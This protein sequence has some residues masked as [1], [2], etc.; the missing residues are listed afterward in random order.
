MG[1]VIADLNA[2]GKADI[3]ASTVSGV[4]VLLGNGDGTFRNV[5]NYA[6]GS[7]H[8]S[9]VA[10]DFTRDGKIDLLTA[11]PGQLVTGGRDNGSL[12]LRPGTGDGSFGE[13]IV[14]EGGG[15]PYHIAVGDFNKDARPDLAV[16]NFVSESASILLN[17]KAL[18]LAEFAPR[19]SYAVTASCPKK[20]VVG[21]FN[22]D[23]KL[24]FA[25]ANNGCSGPGAVNVFIGNGDGTFKKA[26]EY[27]GGHQ[28]EAMTAGDLNG[29]GRLDLV[30]T[31]SG[32]QT[33]QA[34]ALLGRGDGTFAPT[35]AERPVGVLP[36]GATLADLNGDGKLDLVTAN[37]FDSTVSVLAGRGDGTFGEAVTAPSNSNPGALTTADLNGDGRQ[38]VILARYFDS[39]ESLRV[40]RNTGDGTLSSFVDL[41]ADLRPTTVIASDFNGDLKADLAILGSRRREPGILLGQG[42]GTFQ[43]IRFFSGGGEGDLAAA[44][45]NGDGRMDLAVHDE[46][47]SRLI[48]MLGTGDG[49][50]QAA[51][52]EGDYRY[53]QPGGI[54]LGLAYPTLSAGDFNGDGM[55]DL[56]TP[57]SID[58][59][60]VLINRTGAGT[61]PSPM[62][63]DLNEDSRLDV[64]DAIILLQSLVGTV[65]LT[66]SQQSVA[67]LNKDTRINVSDVVALLKAILGL[68][69]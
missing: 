40:Y 4:S 50:F 3:A 49:R 7:F 23:G 6:G 35:N 17:Q 20:V 47:W 67:D 30:V 36:Q 56:V 19:V 68:I 16:A 62:V 39:D 57:D 11:Y 60:A 63:G 12:T 54:E 24:D 18:P 41:T 44:D 58:T 10:A 5:V 64:R 37:N 51:G 33:G 43:P 55:I 21:E 38:D 1:I 52:G 25:V 65:P 46:E 32:G 31:Y 9:L 66:P 45:L 34:M 14:L 59:V 26:V 61:E 42:D 27:H 69:P 2:D 29:D 8:Q 22:G 15:H 28:H 13:P 53:I 48:L